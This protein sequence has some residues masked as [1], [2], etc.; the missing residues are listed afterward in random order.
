MGS[1]ELR[2]FG[3]SKA[4]RCVPLLEF[5]APALRQ[6]LQQLGGTEINQPPCDAGGVEVVRQAPDLVGREVDEQPFGDDQRASTPAAHRVLKQL[7]APLAV[8]EIDRDAL[9]LAARLLP[10]EL[11]M[12]V[13]EQVREVR[14]DP[15]QAAGKGQAV[16]PRVESGGEVEDGVHTVACDGAKDQLVHDR[17]PDDHRPRHRP[18]AR[19][20]LDD[21]FAA[22]AGEPTGVGVRKQGV[23]PLALHGP[24]DRHPTSGVG[25]VRDGGRHL[26]GKT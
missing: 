12:L 25:D 9:E 15:T 11:V 2:A 13:C 21:R 6:H 14:F 20:G 19:H 26:R 24:V 7:A 8:G 4:E 17:R 1:E 16:G 3:G 23:G 18:T 22:R 5:P 10:G